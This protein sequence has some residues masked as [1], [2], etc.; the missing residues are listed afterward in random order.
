VLSDQKVNRLLDGK[1]PVLNYIIIRSFI[2]H[3]RHS[4]K[5]YQISFPTH[6]APHYLEILGG[7]IIKILKVAQKS[8][9][10]AGSAREIF[11]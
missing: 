2:T 3:T 9:N 6:L 4:G 7:V 11:P 1:V 8:N 5:A 10:H